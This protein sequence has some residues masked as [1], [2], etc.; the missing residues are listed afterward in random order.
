MGFVSPVRPLK[1]RT[2]PN[3]G[4]IETAGHHGPKKPATGHSG[5][6]KAQDSVGR[7]KKCV[8]R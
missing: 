1:K 3:S 6:K 5:I 4:G 8:S 7:E 2:G